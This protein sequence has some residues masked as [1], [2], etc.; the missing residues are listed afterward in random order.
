MQLKDSDYSDDGSDVT[1]GDRS[2]RHPKTPEPK[3]EKH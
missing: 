1:V 2:S 3:Q